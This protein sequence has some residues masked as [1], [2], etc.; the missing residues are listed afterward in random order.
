MEINGYVFALSSFLSLRFFVATNRV[1]MNLS[2]SAT[3][4]DI[5]R[6]GHWEEKIYDKDYANPVPRAVSS[7]SFLLELN[8]ADDFLSVL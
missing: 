2:H 8:R 4:S 6:L 1:P 7:T 3:D 5:Q